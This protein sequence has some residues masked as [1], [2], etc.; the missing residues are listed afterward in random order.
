MLLAAAA[1][2]LTPL[3][4]ELRRSLWGGG[5]G[6]GAARPGDDGPRRP[7]SSGS[8]RWPW[9]PPSAGCR[10]GAGSASRSLRRVVVMAPWSAYQKYGDPPGNRLTKWM[11]AG[12]AEIDDRGIAETIIDA[13]GEAGFGGTLHNK[14]REL[15]RRS[16][17]AGRC[18]DQR[19]AR[20]SKRSATVDP[21]RSAADPLRSS[22]STCCPRWACCWPGPWR[23]RSAAPPRRRDPDEWSFALDLLRGLRRRRRRLGPADVRRPRRADR[24][25]PGQLPAAACSGS[26]A[27]VARAAGGVPPLRRLVASAFN[28]VLMLALYVPAFEPLPRQLLLAPGGAARRR[29]P[30][31]V[32]VLSLCRAARRRPGAGRS[33]ARRRQ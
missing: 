21:R 9:S 29:R 23:W 6:R 25:P 8:S 11:L 10:A 17:A 27:C 30:G 3:W 24:D 19:Q 16:S 2:V 26:S 4:G 20:P 18:A 14:G 7:A 13:Y 28:A 31:R 12:D 32:R 22:S 15:R 33:G 5:A 1:L